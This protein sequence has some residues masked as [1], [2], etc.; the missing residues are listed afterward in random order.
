MLFEFVLSCYTDNLNVKEKVV[1]ECAVVQ[2]AAGKGGCTHTHR[3]FKRL[4]TSALDF[5]VKFSE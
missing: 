2:C 5:S 1:L 3:D 4:G